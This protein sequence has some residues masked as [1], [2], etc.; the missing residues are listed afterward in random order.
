MATAILDLDNDKAS[1]IVTKKVDFPVWSFQILGQDLPASAT[2]PDRH[3]TLGPSPELPAPK[4]GLAFHFSSPMP[5]R[6]GSYG[7]GFLGDIFR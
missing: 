2:E 5:S 4:G 6:A 7:M 1:T 3:I